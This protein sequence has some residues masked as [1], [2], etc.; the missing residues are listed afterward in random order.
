MLANE[1]GKDLWLNLPVSAD[2]DYVT[3]VAQMLRYGSDGVNPYASPQVKPAYPPLQPNLAAYL[4]YSNEVWNFSFQQ[5]TTN[6]NL[7]VAEVNTGPSPLNYDGSTNS[8]YWGWRRVAQRIKDISD[9][10]RAVWGNAAMGTRIRPVLEWQVGNGQDTADQ[11]LSFLADYYDNA[12]GIRHVATPHPV[13]YFLWGGGGAWYH[14]VNDQAAGSI[15]AI[16]ASGLVQP[17]GVPI[18]SSWSKAFGLR[19]TAYEG[20]FEIGG[21]TPSTLQLAANLDLRAQAMASS[22]FNYYFSQGGDLALIYTIAGA[23]AYGLADPT[24]YD[25]NT[26]KLAAV[27]AFAASSLPARA[28]G[29]AVAGTTV[30]PT[31]AADVA[32]NMWGPWGSTV[33]VG[34]G[35]WINWTIRVAAAGYYAI[36]TNL[37]SVPGQQILLDGRSISNSGVQTTLTGGLHSLRV[38]YDGTGSLALTGLSLTTP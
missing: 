3:H 15:D 34:N 22:G 10:F 28:I 18:D 9:D 33:S 21:D 32:H 27:Q 11:Q 14:S 6:Y 8:Y 5:A 25:G 24:I 36:S 19:E 38:R 2:D 7:A 4:E 35:C 13:S 23:S 31:T 29:L 37:G 17:T 16:Y 26:P 1:T 30:L 20:G 12:D